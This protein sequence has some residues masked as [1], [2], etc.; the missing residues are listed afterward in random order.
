MVQKKTILI[1]DDHSLFRDGIK[2]IIERNAAFEVVG[3]AGTM[4][5]RP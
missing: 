3:E 1:I 5:V 2:A 4:G